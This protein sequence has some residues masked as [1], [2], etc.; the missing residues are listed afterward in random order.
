[1]AGANCE[2]HELASGADHRTRSA[3][4]AVQGNYADVLTRWRGRTLGALIWRNGYLLDS[5]TKYCLLCWFCAS[6]RECSLCRG[7]ALVQGCSP[8]ASKEN[9]NN[10]R[11]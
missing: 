5:D 6:N 3:F 9:Q 8:V 1:M 2:A 11:C 7:A 10:E 4:I